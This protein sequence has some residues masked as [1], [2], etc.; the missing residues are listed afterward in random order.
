[1][2]II[3]RMDSRKYLLEVSIEELRELNPDIDPETG[4][5]YDTLKAAQTLKSLR[6]LS[7]KKMTDVKIQ[8]DQLQKFYSSVCDNHDEVMLLDT[9]A[10]IKN[11][12]D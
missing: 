11:D 9:I 8:I 7:R 5:E 1:M 12:H 6:S 3:A 4:A 10:N 2:K